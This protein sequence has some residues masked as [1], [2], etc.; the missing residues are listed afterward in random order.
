MKEKVS[1]LDGKGPW[2]LDCLFPGWTGLQRKVEQGSERGDW[3]S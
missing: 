1:V 3:P 2:K